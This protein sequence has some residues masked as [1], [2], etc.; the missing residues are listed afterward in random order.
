MRLREVFQAAG[1]LSGVFA[2]S[3]QSIINLIEA[4][5]DQA[6]I[7]RE[8]TLVAGSQRI[9]DAAIDHGWSGKVKIAQSPS[10]KH[11]MIAFSE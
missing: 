5:G 1:V 3:E 4:A 8:A 11:M 6:D 2:H 10:N 7:L 9:A